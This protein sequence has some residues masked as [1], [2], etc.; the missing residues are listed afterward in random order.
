MSGSVLSG[1]GPGRELF[2]RLIEALGDPVGPPKPVFI[3]FDDVEMA[4]AS[5]VR[6][7]VFAFR[8]RVRAEHPD[9]YP[10][11]ANANPAILEDATIIAD[12]VDAPILTCDLDKHGKAKHVRKIGRLD[13]KAQR[14]FD[15]V[16]KLARR[17]ETDVR[18]LIQAS[19]TDDVAKPTAWSNRLSALVELGL[20][21]EIPDGRAKRY[22][23]VLQDA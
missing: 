4:S 19:G 17:G 9:L 2:G 5:F 22:R 10:V 21:I 20:I 13:D 16:S 15:L 3:D 1:A 8:A 11:I 23:P 7:S 14:T 6:E 12:R 18:A